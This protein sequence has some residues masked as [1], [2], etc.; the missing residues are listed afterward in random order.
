MRETMKN[1]IKKHYNQHWYSINRFLHY[2]N[3]I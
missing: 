1:L 3:G 2:R